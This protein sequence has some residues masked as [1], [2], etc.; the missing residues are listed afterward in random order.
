MVSKRHVWDRTAE[1]SSLR[2]EGSHRDG[3]ETSCPLASP[4]G[5]A[6]G[7]SPKLSPVTW[8]NL[9]FSGT[10]LLREQGLLLRAGIRGRVLPSPGL[11][12][13]FLEEYAN[14]DVHF[15]GKRVPGF[16]HGQGVCD[17]GDLRAISLG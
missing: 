1:P 2:A 16:H 14:D 15:S 11:S 6:P 17:S 3:S 9:H 4:I 10:H 7:E 12:L 5:A 8:L 13:D